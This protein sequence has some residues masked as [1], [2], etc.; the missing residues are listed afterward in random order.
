MISDPVDILLATYNG[1]N[2]LSEQIDSILAQSHS[3]I[4]I[5]AR[6]DG[7]I[8]NTKNILNEYQNKYPDKFQIIP[9]SG[10]NEGVARNFLTLISY[11]DAQYIMFCDQDDYWLPEK[12]RKSLFELKKMESE[13][14]KQ[15]PLLIHTNLKV[16]DQNLRLIHPSFWDYSGIKPKNTTLNRLLVQNVITGCTMIFNRYL[17][18]LCHTIPDNLL[19]HDWWL[20]LIASAI[21]EIRYVSEPTVFYRQHHKNIVGAKASI[22]NFSELNKKI[23]TTFTRPTGY[24]TDYIRQAEDLASI[25]RDYLPEKNKKILKN[26]IDLKNQTFFQK[27]INLIRHKFLKGKALQA[28]GQVIR[29]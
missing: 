15:T 9:S 3:N 19:M 24:L 11:A 17:A 21:G 16:V 27:R 28:I 26:F 5:L 18:N 12:I 1:E 2:Y 7:S 25:C 13:F 22:N 6:D 8:D 14:G 20:G 23:I 4:R 29:F 10:K